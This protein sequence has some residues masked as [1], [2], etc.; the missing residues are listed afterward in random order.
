MIS[1]NCD[2]LFHTESLKCGV[3]FHFQP[4]SALSCQTSSAQWAFVTPSYRAGTQGSGPLILAHEGCIQWRKRKMWTAVGLSKAQGA[5]LACGL[6][7]I[8]S[9]VS[10]GS[11]AAYILVLSPA[12]NVKDQTGGCQNKDASLQ[13]YGNKLF[14]LP[15]AL[16]SQCTF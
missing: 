10:R 16:I 8:L 13:F 7:V 3:C 15:T 12:P 14:L 4:I 11:S 1:K 6:R 2:I 5:C 9:A